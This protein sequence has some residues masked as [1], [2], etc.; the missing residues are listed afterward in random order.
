VR[1][2]IGIDSEPLSECALPSPHTA[3]HAID[4]IADLK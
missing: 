4:L 1:E 3:N 2:E